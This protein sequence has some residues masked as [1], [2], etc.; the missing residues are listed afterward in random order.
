M[1]AR[2]FHAHER[3]GVGAALFFPAATQHARIAA[4]LDITVGQDRHRPHEGIEPVQAGGRGDDQFPDSV[5]MP[6]VRKFMVQRAQQRPGIAFVDPFGQKD[7][8]AQDAV[9]V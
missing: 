1:G 5:K 9:S 2:F 4:K 8:R 6:N 7:H 3:A